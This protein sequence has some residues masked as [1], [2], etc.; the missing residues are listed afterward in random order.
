MKDQALT[1]LQECER[2]ILDVFVRH[3]RD[4][5]AITMESLAASA[6]IS[7]SSRELTTALKDLAV[8]GIIQRAG[9]D[10]IPG[11]PVAFRLSQDMLRRCTDA[12]RDGSRRAKATLPH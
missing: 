9:G 6:G 3:G 5:R 1:E 8:R 2:K 4:G 7:V 10:P 11:T 12:A